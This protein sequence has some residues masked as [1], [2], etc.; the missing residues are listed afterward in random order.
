MHGAL[1]QRLARG[2]AELYHQ[3]GLRP[4]S[5]HIIYDRSEQRAV[6]RIAVLTQQAWQDILQPFI[7]RKTTT[8]FLQQ[9]KA[10]VQAEL[11]GYRAISYQEWV[12]RALFGLA[13]KNRFQ[14]Q[15][16]TPVSFRSQGEYMIFPRLDHIWNNLA[17]KWNMFSPH[18]SLDDPELVSQLTA[19]S[20]IR[21]Y[22]LSSSSF[23]LEKQWIPAFQGTVSISLRGPEP[24][25][26]IARILA[27]FAEFSGLG[28]KTALGMGGVSIHF[29]E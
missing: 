5:Q 15:L 22:Q 18:I 13:G 3:A 8:L 7:E 19:Y 27:G 1:M 23:A 24:L 12:E 4:Y 11:C 16:R 17:A 2:K 9:K 29:G 21:A 20:S 25:L 10:E 6:W 14:L 26:Q 28:I